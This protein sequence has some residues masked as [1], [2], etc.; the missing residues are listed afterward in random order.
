MQRLALLFA[1]LLPL[2]AAVAAEFQIPFLRRP[3]PRPTITAEDKVYNAAEE[4]LHADSIAKSCSSCISLLQ[5]VKNLSYMSEGF[6]LAALANACKRTQKVDAQVVIF[7][8][9]A[10]LLNCVWYQTIQK[11]VCWRSERTRASSSESFA[12]KITEAR[13]LILG[14]SYSKTII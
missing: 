5:V 11:K 6:L 1:L 9:L 3:R 7:L 14:A 8:M 10:L 12:G 4:W 2:I 13:K